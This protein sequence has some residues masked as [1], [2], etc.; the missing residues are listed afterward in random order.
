[1]P[2]QCYSFDPKHPELGYQPAI[3]EPFWYKSWRTWFRYTA[4]CYDRACTR[5]SF[6]GETLPMF[7]KTKQ[8]WDN[9][10]VLTH[11]ETDDA[12]N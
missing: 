12:K 11:M 7:F 3:P 10:Y 1:M 9:H 8:E 6:F 4:S 5:K 2:I